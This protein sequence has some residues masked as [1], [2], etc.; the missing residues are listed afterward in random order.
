MFKARAKKTL[1]VI[2]GTASGGALGFIGGNVPGAI[3]GASVGYQ[4]STRPLKDVIFDK[5]QN[6]WTSHFCFTRNTLQK[7]ESLFQDLLIM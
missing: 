7:L 2:A 4:L 6:L 3:I 5:R 1:Y